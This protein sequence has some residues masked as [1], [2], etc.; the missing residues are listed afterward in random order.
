MGE[1]TTLNGKALA[2]NR[3]FFMTCNSIHLTELERT[4]FPGLTIRTCHSLIP[5]HV[6]TL[7]TCT[8]KPQKRLQNILSIT[9]ITYPLLSHKP[10]ELRCKPDSF[11]FIQCSYPSQSHHPQQHTIQIRPTTF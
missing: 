8:L 2:W 10:T 9:P 7:T 6:S 5:Q 3:S 4:Q 1:Q 11:Q